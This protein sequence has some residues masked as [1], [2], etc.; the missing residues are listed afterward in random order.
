MARYRVDDNYNYLF[1]VVLIGDSGI[2]K[3]NMLST[4]TK[5]VE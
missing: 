2:D 5:N 1:K 3:S 4:F